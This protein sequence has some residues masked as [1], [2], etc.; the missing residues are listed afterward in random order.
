M[1]TYNNY[2]INH[3]NGRPTAHP[4]NRH[5]NSQQYPTSSPRK[6]QRLSGKGSI[7]QKPKSIKRS[8]AFFLAGA[9]ATGSLFLTTQKFNE[10]TTPAPTEPAKITSTL[11]NENNP[12]NFDSYVEKF[13]AIKSDS[14]DEVI[15]SFIDSVQNDKFEELKEYILANYNASVRNAQAEKESVSNSNLS[16]EEND[17][18]LANRTEIKQ[19]TVVSD[20]KGK[21]IKVFAKLFDK[22]DELLK[23]IELE[24]GLYDYANSLI[25]FISLHS[26]NDQT[27]YKDYQF[28][29]NFQEKFKEL[30]DASKEIDNKNSILVYDADNANLNI[31]NFVQTTVLTPTNSEHKE[32]SEYLDR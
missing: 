32:Q 13:E 26:N 18:V 4:T 30:V 29:D 17:T 22:N 20:E 11:I 7:K 10:L 24:N 28:F 23:K 15:N 31:Q 25:D 8:L 2:Y 1:S 27:V 16:N 21:T 14:G 5:Q 6:R 12:F 19:E 3:S 9:I